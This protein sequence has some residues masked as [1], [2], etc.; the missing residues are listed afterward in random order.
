MMS[1]FNAVASLYMA[2]SGS[3]SF[4]LDAKSTGFGVRI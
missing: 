4:N 2:A 1:F 3:L